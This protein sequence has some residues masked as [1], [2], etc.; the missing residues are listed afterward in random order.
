MAI[1]SK[2]TK[3][4]DPIAKAALAA[5]AMILPPPASATRNAT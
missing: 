4:A 3:I 5:D 2:A 1:M